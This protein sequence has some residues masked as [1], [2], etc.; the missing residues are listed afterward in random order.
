MEDKIAKLQAAT[1]ESEEN[2][3]V[4]QQALEMAEQQLADVKAKYYKELTKE[5]QEKLQVNDTELPE[6]IETQIRAKNL[7]ETARAR[8]NTNKRY[9]DAFQAKLGT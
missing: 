1:D 8:Y 2:M 7:Y 4:C 3:K 9:L 6:L 5:E